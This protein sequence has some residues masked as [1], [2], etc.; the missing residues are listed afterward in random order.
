[1]PVA[2]LPKALESLLITCIGEFDLHQWQISNS[3]NGCMIKIKFNTGSH[4]DTVEPSVKS[5]TYKKKSPAQEKRD[6][7]RLE[8]FKSQKTGHNMTTRSKIKEPELKRSDSNMDNNLLDISPISVESTVSVESNCSAVVNENQSF[9]TI[10]SFNSVLDS[11]SPIKEG[12]LE[13]E[14]PFNFGVSSPFSPKQSNSQASSETVADAER[15]VEHCVPT[16]DECDDMVCDTETDLQVLTTTDAP[17]PCPKEEKL[18]SFCWK[19][20]CEVAKTKSTY[21]GHTCEPL[22]ESSYY[23]C[24]NCGIEL[25]ERCF[26]HSTHRSTEAKMVYHEVFV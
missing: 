17:S 15:G 7:K 8:T 26:S 11:V 9:G 22:F 4:L 14:E 12:M 2:G 13:F 3:K 25:C 1:M 10:R 16:D 18:K 24:T 21:Q 19:K 5:A 6:G 23:E 20:H